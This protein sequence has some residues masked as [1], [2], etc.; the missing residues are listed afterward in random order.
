MALNPRQRDAI[1][2]LQREGENGISTGYISGRQ[3]LRKTLNSLVRRGLAVY[4]CDH[5]QVMN[6]VGS[7]K[8][9][10]CYDGSFRYVHRDFIEKHFDGR[11]PDDLLPPIR[12]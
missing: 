2:H 10:G 4:V 6:P 7:W 3:G 12:A 8:D 1:E 9:L 11:L 5:L